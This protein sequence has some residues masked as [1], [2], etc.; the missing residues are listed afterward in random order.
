MYYE[1]KV[2]KLQLLLYKGLYTGGGI[3]LNL[4]LP[5]HGMHSTLIDGALI[6]EDEH[7]LLPICEIACPDKCDLAYVWYDGILAL[8]GRAVLVKG[9]PDESQE[10]IVVLELTQYGVI[11]ECGLIDINEYI[12]IYYTSRS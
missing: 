3:G 2:P 9:D 4:I 5:I 6:E 10:V 11:G 8:L 1:R 12:Y 7:L